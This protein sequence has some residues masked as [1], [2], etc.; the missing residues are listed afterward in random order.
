M[1]LSTLACA[2]ALSLASCASVPA[3]SASAG[4]ARTVL[5]SFY[6]HG[7]KLNTRAADGSVFRPDA[8]TCAHRTLAFGS[9]LRVSRAGRSVVVTVTDRGPAAWTG[10]SLDLTRGA[11]ARLGMLGVG[12]APVTMQVLR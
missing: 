8:M 1:K 12:V 2:G 5:A 6:G 10:R 4:P 7:E 9:R 11:A 3:P